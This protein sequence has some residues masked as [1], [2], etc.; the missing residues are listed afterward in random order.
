MIFVEDRE[1]FLGWQV[2]LPGGAKRIWHIV[3]RFGSPGEAWKATEKQLVEVGGF[4]PDGAREL[5][6][7][8]RGINPRA[9]MA[10]LEKNGV[11]YCYIGDPCYPEPLKRIFDPPPG[12]FVRGSV[13]GL[14]PPAVALV[15]SRKATR[16]GLA[17]A[18]K[19]AGD[20]A[21][22][23]V[24]VVSGMARG[25]DTAAHRGALDA[26]GK[27]VAVL[28]CGVDVAYPAENRR[29]MEEIERSG[30]VVSEFPL[31]ATPQPWHFPVRNRIISGLSLGVVV[32]EAAERSGAL[33]TADFALDQGREVMA[34]P[35]NITSAVSRGPNRL[36][37]QGAR[38]VEGAE[39]ILEELGLGRLFKVDRPEQPA[40]KVS[41]EEAA[42]KN[43]LSAEP[44][45]LDQLVERTGLPAQR[46]LAAL[47]FLELKGLARQLPGRLYAAAGYKL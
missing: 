2:L 39:D 10:L 42:V 47:T 5:S 34:V 44:S 28:G 9:E 26:G 36:I 30:A 41:P 20:L 32:V 29:L 40:V 27:T 8:R 46:V 24:A 31:R 14:W 22:A 17:T 21:L 16:Y 1:F 13:D 15:G 43:S 11:K 19:L 45:N 4:S 6:L 18:G 23:G 38:L 7:R 35:G 37:A 33:I 25:I 12:L 3:E